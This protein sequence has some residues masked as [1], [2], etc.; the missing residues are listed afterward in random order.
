[1]IDRARAGLL[2]AFA[3]LATTAFVAMVPSTTLVHASTFTYDDPAIARVDAHASALAEPGQ[4]L[5]GDVQNRSTSSF[6]E[7]QGASTTS[8]HSFVATKSAGGW[9]LPVGGGGKTIGGRWYTEHALER[10]APN[11]PEVMAT[12]ESRALARANAAGLSPGTPE[13]G[14]WWAKNGPAPRNVPPMVV[15]AEILNPGSTSVRVITNSN[16]DV[17]T[18]IPR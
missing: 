17:V 2:L 6:A 4:S 1:M 14:A 12:L 18:V 9:D 13:F 16:G 15:E 7:A 8:P 3:V 5:R 11:T 10:M